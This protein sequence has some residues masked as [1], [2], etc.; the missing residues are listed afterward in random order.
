MSEKAKVFSF[1]LVSLTFIVFLN[2]CTSN[3]ENNKL[4]SQNKN[5]LS[6]KEVIEKHSAAIM[7]I[8]GVVGI[9]ESL[10][11]DD[12]PSITIMIIEKNETLLKKLPE[13]L[14]GYP[15][16]IEETGEIKPL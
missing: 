8:E 3:T 13:N 2:L 7:E 9:Y 16:I 15:V 6:V 10:L 14:G 11:E 4:E 5:M 1:L 12:S